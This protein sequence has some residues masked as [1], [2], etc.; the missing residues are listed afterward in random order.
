MLDI[1]G[2][3]NS[4]PALIFCTNQKSDNVALQ[5]LLDLPVD[6]IPVDH[7]AQDTHLSADMGFNQASS[8]FSALLFLSVPTPV[9]LGR[10]STRQPNQQGPLKHGHF[11]ILLVWPNSLHSDSGVSLGTKYSTS[12]GFGYPIRKN[13]RHP[14]QEPNPDDL[15]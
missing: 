3:D 6:P 2:Q 8:K 12:L 14:E 10:F 9:A 4:R 5:R 1:V 15:S 7:A 11:L 13:V